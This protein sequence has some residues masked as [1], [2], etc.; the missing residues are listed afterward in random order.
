MFSHVTHPFDLDLLE[1]QFIHLDQDAM[2][3][4]GGT[5]DTRGLP[6]KSPLLELLD[7]QCYIV[8]EK[9]LAKFVW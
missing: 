7:K 8:M 6:W 3:L 5:F 2:S 1:S 4:S 9:M